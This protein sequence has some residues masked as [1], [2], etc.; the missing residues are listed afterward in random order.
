MPSPLKKRKIR[1]CQELTSG[2]KSFLEFGFVMFDEDCEDF[3]IEILKEKWQD[4]SEDIK[5]EYPQAD[6]FLNGGN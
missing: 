5:A 6:E 2:E 1:S 3:D 4:L